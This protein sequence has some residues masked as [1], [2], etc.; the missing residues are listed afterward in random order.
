MPWSLV[1]SLETTE[2][3]H[4]L[5]QIQNRHGR[6]LAAGA[7]GDQEVAVGHPLHAGSVGAVKGCAGEGREGQGHE[8]EA[9]DGGEQA[10]GCGV[11][12][13]FLL[14]CWSCF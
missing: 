10:H 13:V 5:V 8:D 14:E 2:G 12:R 9:E 7:V 11:D 1:Q 4:L 3:E 6:D